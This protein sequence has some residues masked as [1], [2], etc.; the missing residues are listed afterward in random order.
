MIALW[1][2]RP[3]NC[4]GPLIAGFCQVVEMP[5]GAVSEVA[6]SGITEV[7]TTNSPPSGA[8]RPDGRARNSHLAAGLA[9]GP[10]AEFVIAHG[11]FIHLRGGLEEKCWFPSCNGGSQTRSRGGGFIVCRKPG[12]G[13][14]LSP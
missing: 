11:A 7:I 1:R 8:R 9:N 6:G 12:V 5:S 10:R 2:A 3:D 13:Q 4:I 14:R